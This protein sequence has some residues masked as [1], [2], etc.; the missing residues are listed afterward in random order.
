MQ[1]VVFQKPRP[2][3]HLLSKHL[4]RVG[5]LMGLRAS[6]LL[7]LMGLPALRL[8][9]LLDAQGVQLLDEFSALRRAVLERFRIHLTCRAA[10]RAA[11]VNEGTLWILIY[12]DGLD[13]P[14]FDEALQIPRTPTLRSRLLGRALAAAPTVMMRRH[15]RSSSFG[16]P[17]KRARSMPE[18]W[19][20]LR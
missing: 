7:R 4:G 11:A 1:N 5:K 16:T 19:P 18:L 17:T 20:R 6:A 14:P 2:H 9:G 13:L 15:G 3:S 12:T 10:A 8:L